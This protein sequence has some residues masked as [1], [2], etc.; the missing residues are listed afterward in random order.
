[1]QKSQ[2]HWATFV[3]KMRTCK[4][5]EKEHKTKD[6]KKLISELHGDDRNF[7]EP[8]HGW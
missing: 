2:S 7:N 4:I 5:Y 1:M 6:E 8:H 3:L